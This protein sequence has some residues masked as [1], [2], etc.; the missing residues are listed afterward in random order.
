MASWMAAWTALILLSEAS[1]ASPGI[2][3]PI[4]S[5]VPP[6]ARVGQP[7]SFVFSSSTFV[8]ASTTTYTLS[9]PPQWLSIDSPARRLYGTPSGGDIGAGQVVGVPVNLVAT[10]ATGSV[11]LGATLVVSRSPGPKLN[12]PLD[13]QIPSF[14]T[15]SGPSTI[16]SLPQTQFRFDLAPNTFLDPSGSPLDYYAVMADNSP[17]PAWI[18][19]SP[20]K[21]SFSGVTPP[22]E[23]LVQPPQRFAFQVVASDVVGFAAASLRFDIVV[24]NDVPQPSTEK[25]RITADKTTISLNATAGEVISSKKLRE[26][27]KVNGKAATSEN[28]VLALV[29]QCPP[30]LSVDKETW[31]IRGVAPET[32]GS[33]SFRVVL[34]DKALNSLNMTIVVGVTNKA[35]TGS[36]LFKEGIPELTATTGEPFSFEIGKYLVDPRGTEV[37][38][39]AHTPTTW[40]RLDSTGSTIIGDVPEDTKDPSL[41]IP[42]VAKS[43]ITGLS[44]TVLLTIRIQASEAT[45]KSPPDSQSPKQLP[46]PTEVSTPSVPD[47]SLVSAGGDYAGIPPN[48]LLLAIL[49]PAFIIIASVTCLLF[50]CY[51]RRQEKRRPKFTGRDISGPI[52]GTFMMNATGPFVRG[53]SFMQEFRAQFDDLHSSGDLAAA[54]EKE[55]VESR[56]TYLSNASV[57]QPSATVRLLPPIEGSPSSVTDFFG[58][59]MTPLVFNGA[60]QRSLR[61]SRYDLRNDRSLSSI[62]ETSFYEENNSTTPAAVSEPSVHSLPHHGPHTIAGAPFRDAVEVHVP[63]INRDSSITHTP[64]SAYTAPRSSPA[65]ASTS[66]SR[67]S[68]GRPL[69]A[70]SR[71]GHYPPIPTPRKFAWPWLKKATMLRSSTTR[72]HSRQQS[73]ETVDTFAYKKTPDARHNQAPVSPPRPARL[74]YQSTPSI[75]PVTRPVTRRGPIQGQ[76]LAGSFACAVSRPPP[77]TALPS[78]PTMGHAAQPFHVVASRTTQPP[79]AQT[80]PSNPLGIATSTPSHPDGGYSDLVGRDPFHIPKTQSSLAGAGDE[81]VDETVQSQSQSEASV[82]PNWTS[83]TVGKGTGAGM[84]T[85]TRI[86]EESPKVG[87]NLYLSGSKEL[88]SELGS[89][90]LSPD[91][92]PRAAGHGKGWMGTSTSRDGKKKTSPVRFVEGSRGGS[93]GHEMIGPQSLSQGLSL[94]S[95]GSPRFL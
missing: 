88:G 70:E 12:V 38:I 63:T 31:E 40:L 56:A 7:F 55:Y 91:K 16:L 60:T 81:W 19:F 8:S 51:R 50:W 58:S 39:A 28:S 64:E 53:C 14:G 65:S 47:N 49:L 6:V 80:V 10:D 82:L 23:S 25:Q 59:G 26:G 41:H 76:S 29:D 44:D 42:V 69:H 9:N 92:W 20:S 52:P 78:S 62:E 77:D 30:W 85:P 86:R 57:P 2:S 3:F 24:G 75:R 37:S 93:G 66:D 79:P 4:N 5:Q 18:S 13:Q 46:T 74:P 83:V 21:L 11:T 89:E 95:E 54:E 61:A 71:M 15:F 32:A 17:I 43:K 1:V 33:I 73:T 72:S 68:D 45:A 87:E 94:A 22:S 84:G 27:V 35:P 36:A 67:N 48:L 34:Q 90:L